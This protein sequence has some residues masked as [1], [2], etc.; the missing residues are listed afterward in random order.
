MQILS[1]NNNLHF[2]LSFMNLSLIGGNLH[3]I[4]L[5]WTSSYLMSLF[6]H[7]ALLKSILSRRSSIK[8]IRNLVF[9]TLW[10]LFGLFIQNEKIRFI[11]EESDITFSFSLARLYSFCINLNI[12]LRNCLHWAYCLLFI[13]RIISGSLGDEIFIF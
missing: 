6:F 8:H 11:S 4:Q 10:A 1:L 3:K 12:L 9:K 2:E 13:P 7:H 5:G